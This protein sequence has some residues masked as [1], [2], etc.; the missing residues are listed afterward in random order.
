M[1]YFKN[2]SV[3]STKFSQGGVNVY[4]DENGEDGWVG[5]MGMGGS[6]FQWHPKLNISIAYLPTYL[7]WSDVQNTRATLL[8][9]C[10][11][12]CIKNTKKA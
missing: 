6:I 10:V 11:I 3:L 1:Y 8:Q 4:E 7:D 5:W 9:R 2:C 12:E